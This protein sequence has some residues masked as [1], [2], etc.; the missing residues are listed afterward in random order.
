D[1]ARTTLRKNLR[2]AKVVG[3]Q[4]TT[5]ADVEPVHTGRDQAGDQRFV[6][7][8]GRVVAVVRAQARA[9]AKAAAVAVADREHLR[10]RGGVGQADQQ[11]RVHAVR[12][13]GK[14]RS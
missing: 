2:E 12:L 4:L 10:E 7:V 11:R 8:V 5:A 6:V 13:A 9:P 14:M 3:E 1:Q